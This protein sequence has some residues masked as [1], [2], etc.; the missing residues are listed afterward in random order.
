MDK[1]WLQAPERPERCFSWE[2]SGVVD[3]KK[4]WLKEENVDLLTRMIAEGVLGFSIAR[5]KR[6]KSHAKIKDAALLFLHRSVDVEWL[7][8]L[9]RWYDPMRTGYSLHRIAAKS[10]ADLCRVMARR[11]DITY[12]MIDRVFHGI[13]LRRNSALQTLFGS[14]SLPIVRYLLDSGLAPTAK[15]LRGLHG[16]KIS[17]VKGMEQERVEADA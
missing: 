16:M 14:G 8:T 3:M 15:Q 10:D 13:E 6:S 5:M 7:L 9:R 12:E 1:T 17:E 2:L 11:K 4:S